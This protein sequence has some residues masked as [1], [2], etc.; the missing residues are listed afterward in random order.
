MYEVEKK[1]DRKQTA[2]TDV[3]RRREFKSCSRINKMTSFRIEQQIN[4]GNA[5]KKTKI[6]NIK[7]RKTRSLSDDASAAVQRTVPADMVTTG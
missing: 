5:E 3:R 1:M 2:L 6:I 7:I 4:A